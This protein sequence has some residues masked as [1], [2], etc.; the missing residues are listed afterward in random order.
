M[1]IREYC[2]TLSVK[3]SYTYNISVCITYAEGDV[4]KTTIVPRIPKRVM[5]SLG[6]LI[7]LGLSV[8]GM[9]KELI[10]FDNLLK[11]EKI[12]SLQG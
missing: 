3:N 7:E 2:P 12:L 4:A 10:V 9:I 5:V 11:I 6:L 1:R 8:R